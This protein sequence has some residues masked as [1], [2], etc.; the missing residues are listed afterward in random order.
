[1]Q[2]NGRV[3]VCCWSECAW[4]QKEQKTERGR[5]TEGH[6]GW[7]VEESL[8]SRHRPEEGMSSSSCPL[9][10]EEWNYPPLCAHTS[11]LLQMT[12]FPLW[13]W[14]LQFIHISLFSM[15]GTRAPFWGVPATA[16]NR[17]HGHGL[18]NT[19][20]SLW[21]NPSEVSRGLREMS[22]RCCEDQS[23]PTYRAGDI[24]YLSLI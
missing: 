21:G 15:G 2:I 16:I 4:N 24:S 12:S 13:N 14:H 23:T 19:A 17:V 7:R 18:A 1:M 5:E 9:L 10:A 3:V 11:F 6:K 22:E 20:H 8:K